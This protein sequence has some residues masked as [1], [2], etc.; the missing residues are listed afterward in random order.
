LPVNYT[1][2]SHYS[3]AKWELNKSQTSNFH[4]FKTNCVCQSADDQTFGLVRST[5]TI[6]TIK[7][8]VRM[9]GCQFPSTH[10][11]FSTDLGPIWV[12]SFKRFSFHLPE[13]YIS[14]LLN[15][16]SELPVSIDQSRFHR[17][18]RNWKLC[19]ITVYKLPVGPEKFSS[20][21][22][23]N[24]HWVLYITLIVAN[25]NQCITVSQCCNLHVKISRTFIVVPY[26]QCCT[27]H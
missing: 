24:V 12:L 18:T 3:S 9:S 8:A 15:K 13:A 26:T 25:C 20:C 4:Y 6:R 16:F 1:F 10:T 7:P 23:C 5:P 17:D 19:W 21:L 22:C 14:E 27:L 11:A 2:I